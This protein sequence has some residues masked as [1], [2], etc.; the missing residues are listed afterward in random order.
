MPPRQSITASTAMTMQRI[1][2]GTKRPMKGER[3]I[4]ALIEFIAAMP[5]SVGMREKAVMMKVEKAKKM[6]AT[7]PLP[8]AAAAR[9]RVRTICMV[10]RSIFRLSPFGGHI[11]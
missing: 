8:I 7:R 11:D 4:V 6:P 3:T 5:C 10:R 9:E 2:V 1:A